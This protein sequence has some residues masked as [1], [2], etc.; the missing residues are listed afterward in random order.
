MTPDNPFV[1][2]DGKPSL[3]VREY[4]VLKALQGILSGPLAGGDP[5]PIKPDD[6]ARRAVDYANALLK[7]LQQSGPVS[8]DTR[9]DR[10]Q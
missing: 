8:G 3:N 2:V 4:F 1:T 7:L 9:F 6:A 5:T 10:H